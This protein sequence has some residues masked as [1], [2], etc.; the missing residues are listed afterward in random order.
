MLGSIAQGGVEAKK[1]LLR[2]ILRLC[3]LDTAGHQVPI[4]TLTFPCIEIGNGLP[5][6]R[7]DRDILAQLVQNRPFP[8]PIAPAG[9]MD[10]KTI[11]QCAL[12]TAAC[13]QNVASIVKSEL[14]TRSHRILDLRE[15]NPSQAI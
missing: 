11:E 13:G 9:P 5:R 10:R 15:S 8:I 7:T 14:V 4:K 12:T 2:D 3:R 6:C 1:R